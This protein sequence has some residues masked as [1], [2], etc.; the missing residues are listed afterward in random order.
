MVLFRKGDGRDDRH[1]LDVE[2][3]VVHVGLYHGHEGFEE[4][5]PFEAGLPCREFEFVGEADLDP[6]GTALVYYVCVNLGFLL[7][8]RLRSCQ[9]ET[10][11]VEIWRR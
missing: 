11:A 6:A 1:T 4:F 10:R 7:L 5:S 9:W 2:V 8:A 3:G